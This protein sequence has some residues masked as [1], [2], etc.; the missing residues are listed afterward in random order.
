MT[1]TTKR[2]AGATRAPITTADLPDAALMRLPAVLS[3]IPIGR[4]SW[5]RGIKLGKYPAPIRLGPRSVAWRY[6][7]IKVLLARLGDGEAA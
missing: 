6:G 4:A 1:Q 5:W 3:L 2:S 7:D